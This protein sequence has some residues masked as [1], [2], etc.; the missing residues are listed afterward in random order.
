MYY[1]DLTPYDYGAPTNE[2][3]IGWL[4]ISMPFNKWNDNENLVKLK[5][6]FLKLF[7]QYYR[8]GLYVHQTR[9]FHGCPFCDEEKMTGSN[10]IRVVSLDGTVYASPYLI[11]H[12][13]EK[14]DYLPPLCF[15]M[16][17]LKGPKP[18][19]EE[20][21]TAINNVEIDQDRVLQKK[22]NSERV[23]RKHMADLTHSLV[24]QISSEIDICILK[25][26]MKK[27]SKNLSFRK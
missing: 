20:Y 13:I 23:S 24:E 26:I 8:T 16:G 21:K 3:N 17:V 7:E 14:H 5:S 15:I 6:V 25:D 10:E 22:N 4:D 27:S 12:Y 2:L 18:G 1:D 11:Y 19:T 9:G